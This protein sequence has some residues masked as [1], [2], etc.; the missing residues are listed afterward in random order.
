MI[1]SIWDPDVQETFDQ[2]KSHKTKVV[3]IGD[4]S[5]EIQTPF[6]SPEDWRDH[7]I[8]FL[9]VDRFNNPDASPAN[10]PW[11]GEHGVFQGG[12]FNGIRQ[13][14]EYLKELGVGAIWLS[15]VLKNCQ[16]NPFA[17]HGYGIQDFFQV[18][19]RFAADPEA[20]KNNPALVEDELRALIDEAHA[21][22]IYIIFDIV[23]NHAGDVFAYRDHGSEAPWNDEVYEIN[24]RDEHGAGRHDWA[25][26]PEEPPADAA[27]WPQELLRN[28]MFRRKGKGGELGGDFYSLKEL[29]TDF[30]EFD[31]IRGYCYS[32]HDIL[33][34]SCQYLIAKYDVDGFRIDT[35]KYIEPYFARIFGGAIRE[36]AL[37][38]G[39]KNFF[40]FGEVYDSEEKIARFIGRNAIQTGDVIG[41]DAALDFPLFYKLPSMAKGFNSPCEVANV[42][43]NRKNI[44]RGIISS[45]GE[46]SNF[47]VTFIDNHDQHQ[48]FYYS[49]S[50]DPNQFDDQV[51][52]CLGCLFTLQGIPCLYYGTEQGLHG[53]GSGDLAV[54]EAL[55]GKPD[56]F[57]RDHLFYE[58][59]KQ[60]TELRRSHPAL[61]YGRQY[62]RPVSGDGVQFGISSYQQGVLA[63]SRILSD[64]EILVLANTN[65]TSELS[66]Q[67]IVDF[68]LNPVGTIYEVLFSNKKGSQ[69]IAAGPVVE[70]QS[71][72][73]VIH[74]VNGFVTNGPARTLPLRLQ[75]M[76][77]SILRKMR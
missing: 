75:P 60:L 50:S 42:F 7:W 3:K 38:I 15:P 53:M 29:V 35:L 66:I 57:N 36:F 44:Q 1:K 19:P 22:G 16:Y 8:Y 17:Y 43:E 48:R 58:T 6:P 76:E 10:L 65:S 26:P 23:L 45:H 52:L 9:L 46:A 21:H 49:P 51:T 4:K 59:V 11:D 14:L 20:A 34:H 72:D 68:S 25:E 71:G 12:N 55:W 64:Q 30:R 40:T 56:A 74:E 41:I 24:W 31:P 62:F 69:S 77:I 2:V 33:V 61:L 73:V 39:K 32:V 18:E 67:V 37:S 5:V 70:K 63:F 27:V 47:F 54:R 13:Q 28:Q